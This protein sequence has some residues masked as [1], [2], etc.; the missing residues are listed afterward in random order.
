MKELGRRGG[1]AK[2]VS[3]AQKRAALATVQSGLDAGTL[4]VDMSVSRSN[5]A[6]ATLCI[7][8]N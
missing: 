5:L 8:Q 1:I 4:P 3:M 7:A 6:S 2:G